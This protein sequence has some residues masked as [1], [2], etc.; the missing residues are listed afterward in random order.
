MQRLP[1]RLA[2]G[3]PHRDVERRERDVQQSAR[4]DPVTAARQLLPGRFGLEDAHADQVLA[5]L[6]RRVADRRH[7]VGARVDDVA[8]ARDPV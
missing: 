1:E 4:S 3:V 8:H 6:A 7:E 2:R 5:E